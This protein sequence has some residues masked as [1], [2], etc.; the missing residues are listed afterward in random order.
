MTQTQTITSATP[1]PTQA[2]QGEKARWFGLRELIASVVGIVLYVA[3]T[4]FTS[5]AELSQGLGVELRPSI[6]IPIVFGFAYGP[7]VGFLVGFVGNT[8]ADQV[9]YSTIY[10][11]WE[12]GNGLVGLVPG[13][14]ALFGKSYLTWRDQIL[15]FLV[16]VAGIVVG[17]GFAAFSSMVLCSE[18]YAMSSCFVVPTTLNDAWGTFLAASQTNI[19]SAA[20]LVPVLLYNIARIDPRQINWNSGLL[21][22]FIVVVIVSAALPIALLSVFLLQDLSGADAAN[23]DNVLLVRLAGTIA[24]TVLFTIANATLVAQNLN[25]PLLRLSQAAREME[26]GALDLED[27][28]ALRSEAGEDEVSNLSRIFGKMASE[29]IQRETKLRQQVEQLQIQIDE[30]KRERD[31]EEITDN[32]FF[33][34]LRTKSQELRARRNRTDED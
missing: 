9:L 13:L 33:R 1:S 8:V 11:Q 4:W 3:I 5:F 23:T 34:S 29:V 32:E 6:V 2:E 18:S 28:Q 31:V 25:R 27:A 12:V 22:R 30:K 19:I 21:R 7:V 26:N 17:I 24:V 20:I 15:A 10:W 14:Y 16:S